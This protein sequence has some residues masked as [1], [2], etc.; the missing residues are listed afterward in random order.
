M[1]KGQVIHEKG[2]PENFV[3]EEVVIP[4]PSPGEGPYPNTSD[5]G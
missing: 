5:W 4:A 1:P 2:G 3:W